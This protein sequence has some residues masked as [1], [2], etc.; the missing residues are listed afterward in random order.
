MK[1]IVD[2]GS[3]KTDWAVLKADGLVERFVSKGFNPYYSS[4]EEI[5]ILITE[6][7][8]VSLESLKIKDVYF[9]GTG[10][11]TMENCNLVRSFLRKFFPNAA[12]FVEHDM[13]GAAL[14]LL[15]NK[16]GIACILGTGSNSCLWDGKRIVEN[17]PSL[18]YLIG[19][20]G[21]SVYLGKLLLR[22][23]LSGKAEG[24]IAQAFYE[25]VD[26]NFT[27]I[28][29]KIYKDPEAKQWI[30]CLSHFV[31]ENIN[32]AE[33]EEVAK[34]GFRDFIHNQISEFSGFKEVEISFLGSVAYHLQDVLRE[35]M[36][37]ED[38]KTGLILQSPMDGL[39][40]Y[41]REKG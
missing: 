6:A 18:G 25:Y 30:G 21:S 14:A 8:P 3:T 26:M 27:Q 12:I 39:I 15:K 5:E 34:Q 32:I 36:E 40:D 35:V 17:V 10:C 4:T 29:H 41:F 11:S 31:T 19:D 2:S 24:D 38:L 33:I 16:K 23:I 28:L 20:E 1:L 13:V 9:Y 7:L 22:K 37:E